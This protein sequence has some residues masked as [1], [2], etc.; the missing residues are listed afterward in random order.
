MA[1]IKKMITC[2]IV[3]G[4]TSMICLVV[5]SVL[6]YVH[7]WQ[8][9]KALIGITFTYI[10]SGFAGGHVMRRMSSE[11][12]MSRKLLEGILLGIVFMLILVVLSI[13]IVGDS[14]E[15]SSRFLVI[16]MLLTGSVCLG[17]IL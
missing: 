4:I 1:M 16:W 9:D 14:F 8:A 15:V 2:I 6:S 12:N 5:V 7:K 10:L 17:R 3:M 13:T 11:N